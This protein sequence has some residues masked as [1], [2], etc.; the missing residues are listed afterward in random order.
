MC[1]LE[2]RLTHAPQD[3]SHTNT[4]L[5][6]NGDLSQ[7]PKGK[8]KPK[9]FAELDLDMP[10]DPYE[11]DPELTTHLLST[12]FEYI[13]SAT[14]TIFPREPFMR[15]AADCR[16]KS[17]EDLMLIYAMLAIGTFYSQRPERL[18]CAKRFGI[19]ARRS[20]ERSFGRFSLQL[21]Q[22]RM[23][24]SLYH[25]AT[26]DS[27]KAWDYC[28][29]SFRAITALGLGKEPEGKLLKQATFDFEEE[30]LKECYR[31]TFWSAYLMDR[32]TG[33]CVG[34]VECF[35]NSDVFLRLP[36]SYQQYQLGVA[37]KAPYFDNNFIDPNLTEYR[38]PSALGNMAYICQA[39]AIWGDIVNSI[40]RSVHRHP[41]RYG[42]EHEAFY[43]RTQGRL[44]MWFDGLPEHLSLQRAAF[45]DSLRTGIF[46]T[47]CKIHATHATSCMK[48]S[49]HARWANL[50]ERSIL[51]GIRKARQ[52]A[53]D[54][55]RVLTDFTPDMRR[56]TNPSYT[57]QLA[58]PFV[59]VSII[60]AV[61][62]VTSAGDLHDL[63]E[64]IQLISAALDIIQELSTI[65]HPA[66]A[67]YKLLSGRLRT[68]INCLSAPRRPDIRGFALDKP[69]EAVLG[70]EDDLVYCEP[71][72]WEAF[73]LH[74]IEAAD[75]EGLV[76]WVRD[77]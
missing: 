47:Y 51:R 77:G 8:T 16:E 74:G 34:K 57:K 39:A 61:D 69:L 4:S 35:N 9:A 44:A 42:P 28:G 33:H 66:R 60:T 29:T 49:R 6:Q 5:R 32:L 50:T 46:P 38:D 64:I 26:G 68:L 48:L 37:S 17:S 18:S 56:R 27:D 76:V 15:W 43:Q 36:C 11:L 23:L 58:T 24:V 71:R 55:L 62:I 1:S 7:N 45:E 21:V 3:R 10:Q 53:F 41:S 70:L 63:N 2:L 30:T 13:N 19:I 65:W 72:R 59:G 12:Y 25:Y 75:G 14:Y 22:A 73:G 40:T 52:S 31:R 20:I 54:W 67:Q